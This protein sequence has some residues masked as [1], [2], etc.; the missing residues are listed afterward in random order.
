VPV[1]TRSLLNLLYVTCQLKVKEMVDAQLFSLLVYVRINPMNMPLFDININILRWRLFPVILV[2]LVGDLISFGMSFSL[3]ALIRTQ[4]IPVMG[5]VV[6]WNEFPHFLLLNLICL[7]ITFA[8]IGLYPGIGISAVEEMRTI[9]TA[10]TL[11]YV[12]FGIAIY[13]QPVG[14]DFPPSVLLPGWFF[15]IFSNLS[16]RYTIRIQFSKLKWW[17]M[18]VA[19]VGNKVASEDV[20]LR[21]QRSRRIGLRPV[22]VLDEG[23]LTTDE[24]VLGLPRI[25]TRQDLLSVSRKHGINSV[26]YIETASPETPPANLESKLWLNQHFQTIYIMP[27]DWPLGSL[28]VRTL[29]MEGRLILQKHNQ[30]LDRKSKIIKRTFDLIL[31]SMLAILLSP[32][33]FC[34]ALMIRLDSPGPVFYSLPRLGYQGKRFRYL[35]FRT[36]VKEA[37]QLLDQVLEQD[38]LARQEYQQHHKLQSDPRITRVGRFLR[39]YSL[40]E[41]PQLWH[42]MTGEMSLVGH[43]AYLINE[44]PGMGSYADLIFQ[45]RPGITGW[46]QVLGR[47]SNTFQHRLQLDEYYL[48]NWSLWLDVYILIRTIWVLLSSHGV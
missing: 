6:H 5:G 3:A 24:C 25:Q 22:L 39:K 42:V 14:G 23:G 10:L 19:I 27:G 28:W 11:G 31:G 20:I 47:H 26:V 32:M 8:F 44:F 46:W 7:L 38:L 21:L 17:G 13:F 37:D 33:L 43:R 30:L 12:V 16:I 48:N 2:M 9:I 40:D 1:S 18:P 15:A 34:I 4:L 41:L 45:M 35:K 36:M 29:D